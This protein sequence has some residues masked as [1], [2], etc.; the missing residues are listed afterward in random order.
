M[1][2]VVTC[3]QGV[4]LERAIWKRIPKKVHQCSIQIM[5]LHCDGHIKPGPF[6]SEFT[7]DLVLPVLLHD[8]RI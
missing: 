3:D 4:R 1:I 8:K 2:Q 7:E 6:D 5:H